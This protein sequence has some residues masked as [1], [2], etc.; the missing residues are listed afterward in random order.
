MSLHWTQYGFR[1]QQSALRLVKLNCQLVLLHYPRFCVL[2]YLSQMYGSG[3]V[4]QP[5]YFWAP[6]GN[7]G[8]WEIARSCLG[9]AINVEILCSKCVISAKHHYGI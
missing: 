2:L 1:N 7:F 5:L 6:A 3:F 8:E 4:H 9:P